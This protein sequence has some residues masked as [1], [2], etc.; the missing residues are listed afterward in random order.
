MKKYFLTGLALL[1]PSVLTLI[2]VLFLFD[3]LTEPF[4]GW[5]KDL[6]LAWEAHL[7]FSI[8]GWVVL[9]SARV[10]AFLFLCLGIF[11]LGLFAR[12]FLIRNFVRFAQNLLSKI[13][14]VKTIYTMTKDILS[15]LFSLDG[16][17]VF[18]EPVS[19]PFPHLPSR[20]LG[21]RAGE[22]AL[23]CQE[24]SSIP[25]VS[26]FVPT[27]PHPISGFLFLVPEKDLEA[28]PMTN[29]EAVKFLV[30]CGMLYTKKP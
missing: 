28:V 10:V 26:V 11:C 2:V 16:K 5:T 19:L 15:A 13:P 9:A 29:E 27:S 23:E 14:V 3:F 18:K 6:V 22:V 17:K 1:L 21:F 7:P 4:I 20:A 30:S 24:A 25:L 12:W 8:P